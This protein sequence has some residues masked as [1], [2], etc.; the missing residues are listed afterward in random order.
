MVQI[1]E[2]KLV[3]NGTTTEQMANGSASDRCEWIEKYSSSARDFEFI[4]QKNAITADAANPSDRSVGFTLEKMGKE[5]GSFG[6]PLMEGSPIFVVGYG[7][8]DP[9]RSVSLEPIVTQGIISSVVRW[10]RRPVM[11]VTTAVVHSGMSG[12]IVVCA[13]T[14]RP[15]AMVVSNSK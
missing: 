11:L 6:A 14:G 7:L 15:L 2:C 12:G 1:D 9:A 8:E 4:N 10:R 13:T 3:N 5:D